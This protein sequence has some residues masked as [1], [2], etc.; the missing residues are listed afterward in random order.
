MK[1][2]KTLIA[3]AVGL[4]FGPLAAVAA[5]DDQTADISF[6][7]RN[8]VLLNI[9]SGDVEVPV[10]ADVSFSDLAAG[11]VEWITTGVLSVDATENWK[12]EIHSTSVSD[13][14]GGTGN[15]TKS[16]GDLGVSI[17]SG[18]SYYNLDA[19]DATFPVEI[20]SSGTGLGVPGVGILLDAIR[21][22]LMLNPTIDVAGT[23]TANLTFTATTD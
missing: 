14:F 20:I 6:R 16:L 10:L 23:Y 13:F 22:K 1:L 7:I 2:K 15:T 8:M 18:S 11:E 9:E 3:I 5:T 21:Y 17:D 4:M 12:L 19:G